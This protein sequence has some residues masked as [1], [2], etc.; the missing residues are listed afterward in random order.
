[1]SSGLFFCGLARF[2]W[3]VG[4]FWFFEGFEEIAV[5]AET[6]LTGDGVFKNDLAERHQSE[7]HV[8]AK[9]G[10]ETDGRYVGD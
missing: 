3:G 6:I 9:E 10:K 1:M 8:G 4:I 5:G 2:F 7:R